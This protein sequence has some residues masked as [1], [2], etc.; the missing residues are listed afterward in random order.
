[1]PDNELLPF[2]Q[3]STT[4][5]YRANTAT[6][7][8]VTY[9]HGRYYHGFL[10]SWYRGTSI[11]LARPLILSL[12]LDNT[13]YV[14]DAAFG[15]GTSWNEIEADQ[16]L[17]RATLDWQFNHKASLD[18]GVRRIVGLFAPTGFGYVPT[19]ATAPLDAMNLTAAFH[20]LALRNEFYV[21]YGDPNQLSTVHALFLKWIRYIGA[22]KGT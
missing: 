21:V 11:R 7:S 8:S 4:I 14:P 9:S 18:V 22:P 3:N 12:E 17:E 2:N 6:G 1:M 15:T 5:S 19:P 13:H 10:S 20:F 16:V